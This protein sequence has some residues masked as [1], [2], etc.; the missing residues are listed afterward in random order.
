MVRTITREKYETL[1]RH[2]Y[3][4]ESWEGD[5]WAMWNEPGVGTVLGAVEVRDEREEVRR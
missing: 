4:G 3:A 5:P 1:R 2:G